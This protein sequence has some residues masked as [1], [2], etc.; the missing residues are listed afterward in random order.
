[1][2]PRAEELLDQSADPGRAST[3]MGLES[4][5]AL[6]NAGYLGSVSVLHTST[7]LQSVS[8]EL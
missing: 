1:M 4:E 5:D 8:L 6:Q 7:T 2:I 3:D